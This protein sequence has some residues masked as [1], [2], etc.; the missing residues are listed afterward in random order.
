MDIKKA[1]AEISALEMEKARLEVEVRQIDERV[2]TTAKQ[3]ADL[4]VDSTTIYAEIERLEQS[5]AERLE[6]AKA[7]SQ[8]KSVTSVA[9]ASVQAEA[10]MS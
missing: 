6:A 7:S 9:K 4:G 2:A 8:P 5:I 3:M 1:L 10:W